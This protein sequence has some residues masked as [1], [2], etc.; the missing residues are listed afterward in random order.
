MITTRIGICALAA[1]AIFPLILVVVPTDTA[2]AAVVESGIATHSV[3]PH[4]YSG[5]VVQEFG[6][7]VSYGAPTGVV[8]NSPIEDIVATPDAKGYLIVTAMGE[9]S[10]FGD[11]VS[12]GSITGVNLQ[13]PIV[14]MAST[15]DG[16]GYWMVAADGGIFTFGD[17]GF[18]G[19]MGGT[20]LNASVVG[21]AST[22]DGEGYWMA[23][24]D[25]G[26]FTFGDA[27]FH[28][29]DASISPVVPITA[30][31]SSRGGNGYWLLAPDNITT[32]FSEPTPNGSFA[33]SQ[34]IVAAADSQIGADPDNVDGAFCNPYGPC[35]EWCA[36]FAT[37]AW[38]QGGIQ[39]PSFPFTGSIYSWA[40]SGNSG[41]GVVP[42]TATPVP[43]DAVLYGSGPDNA[44]TSLHVGIVASVWPDGE[45]ITIEGDAGPA[46]N[47]QMNVIINGPY[48][49]QDS[50]S[51]NG[52]P[53]YA[54][55]Q[56]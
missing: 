43:G 26:V 33:G 49:P 24:N 39:V 30:I 44:N 45:V 56:P 14:G 4:A 38:Q 7:A 13:A 29:S 5:S 35:E 32:N 46:P 50:P 54:F 11:A 6:S 18:H 36:L 1:A 8:L 20:P 31:A 10:P 40:A 48:L 12:Y 37:W 34:Q 51:Y 25:G 16:K 41:G 23:A 53:V 27:G 22:P 55:A 21:M 28:G 42:D 2:S 17:A 15:P 52:M 9:V 19:S 3:Q 47:G